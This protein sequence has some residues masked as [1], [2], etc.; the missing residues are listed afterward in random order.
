M[1]TV[2]TY[3][4]LQNANNQ[5]LAPIVIHIDFSLSVSPSI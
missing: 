1:D 3:P 4:E 2:N 5:D